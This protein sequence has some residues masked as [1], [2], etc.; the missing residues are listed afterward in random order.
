MITLSRPNKAI[1]SEQLDEELR[2]ALNLPVR[3]GVSV[4]PQTITIHTVGDPAVAQAVLDAHVAPAPTAAPTLE[5]RVQK[6]EDA[7]GKPE[8]PNPKIWQ[9]I[10]ALK[11]R[12]A[13]AGIP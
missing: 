7:A 3:P 13:A 6:L 5:E 10:Q 12:L 11:D 1:D 2:A 4:G 9:E 8:L